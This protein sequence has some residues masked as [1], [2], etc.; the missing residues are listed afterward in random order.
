MYSKCKCY[1]VPVDAKPLVII[2]TAV[3]VS[4]KT[5]SLITIIMHFVV[6]TIVEDR[7]SGEAF[8]HCISCLVSHYKI[9]FSICQVSNTKVIFQCCLCLGELF[10]CGLQWVYP[11]P[12]LTYEHQL[13]WRVLWS[14]I[15]QGAG[16]LCENKKKKKKWTATNKHILSHITARK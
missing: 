10:G 8:K 9:C 2:K 7:K 15:L 12:W 5:R 11:R 1:L 3:M 4:T 14:G 13:V 6:L 16:G